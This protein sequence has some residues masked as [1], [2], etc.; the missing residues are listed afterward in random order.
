[1]SIQITLALIALA[2]AVGIGIGYFLRL[3]ITL[4]KRGSLELEIRKMRLDAEERAK[5]ITEE[6]EQKAKEKEAHLSSE[7]KGREKD[8]KQTE[9]RRVRKEELLDKRQTN[10]EA[11]SESLTKKQADVQTAKEKADELVRAQQEKLEKVANLSAEEAKG[12]LVKSIERQYE[13]DLEGRMRKLEISGN[14]RLEQRAKEILTTSV[15]RLGNSVVS[16]VLA[17]TMTL[18]NDEIKGKIIGK[19]GRNIRA[20]ERATGVDVIVDDTPGTITLSSYDPIRRQI[21][22]I[23]LENLILDGRIQPAKIEEAVVKAEAEINTIIK[24]K[25]AEAAYAAKVPNLDPKLLM[26]LGRL[27][28]RTSYG[29]NVLDHSVEVA[30]LAGMLARW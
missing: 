10:L 16:D 2:G 27:Y 12:D 25:G 26:I 28:F 21:A 19:E 4:G 9:E 1:M 13:T 20:F 24:K 23:A 17:T 22:R 7:F 11:E 14:E 3:I 29:Q 18:P 5:K 6:A 8:L 30:H 15:H